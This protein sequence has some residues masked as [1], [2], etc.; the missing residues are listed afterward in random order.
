VKKQGVRVGPVYPKQ[1]DTEYYEPTPFIQLALARGMYEEMCHLGVI[2]FDIDKQRAKEYLVRD[3]EAADQFKQQCWVSKPK[4]VATY[5]MPK[6]P[7]VVPVAESR[8]G[9][10]TPPPEQK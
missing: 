3:P 1:I 5:G 7:D 4:Y 10:S 8:K 6:Q 2:K 9:S